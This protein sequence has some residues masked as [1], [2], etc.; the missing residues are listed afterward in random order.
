MSA[1]PD[2]VAPKKNLRT[3][4]RRGVRQIASVSV[5]MPRWRWARRG[6]IQGLLGVPSRRPVSVY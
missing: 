3:W 2:A 1:T 5:N 6:L 4:L